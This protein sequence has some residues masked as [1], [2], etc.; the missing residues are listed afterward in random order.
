MLQRTLLLCGIA[1][2]LVYAAINVA[3]PMTWPR[4]SIADET[5]SELSAIGAPTRQLWMVLVVPYIV[6][7]AAF[8]WGVASTAG[9]NRWLRL[10][11]WLILLYS[12]FNA[13]WP[14]MHQR[15]VLAAGGGTL[16]DLLH[17]VWAGVTVFL[18]VLIMAFGAAGLG[19]RFRI[20]TAA[21]AAL[22]LACGL[23]TSLQAPNVGANLPTPWIGVWERINIA[24]F[25]A[26]VAVLSVLLLRRHGSATAGARR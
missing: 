11:G 9:E 3:V 26:W 23:A 25:L 8:G 5:V 20:Y 16:T 24:A 6:L 2:S 1:S 14:P 12:A 22:L 18:F 21:S 13:Y 17:L 15:E 10:T 7:F 4:Y 19:R